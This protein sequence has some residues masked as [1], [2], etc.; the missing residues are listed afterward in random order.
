MGCRRCTSTLTR[1]NA[2]GHRQIDYLPLCKDL[3]KVK[4]TA[5]VDVSS[6]WARVRGGCS[7]AYPS[8]GVVHERRR[9]DREDQV[10]AALGIK[11]RLSTVRLIGVRFGGRSHSRR[12]VCCRCVHQGPGADRYREIATGL[13]VTSLCVPRSDSSDPGVGFVL[14]VRQDDTRSTGGHSAKSPSALAAI[15]QLPP[16]DALPPSRLGTGSR[17][18]EE[19][20]TIDVSHLPVP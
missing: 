20:E 18:Q 3:A 2:Y 19:R 4:A 15:A 6:R 7:G 1:S 16:R 12:R 8:F 13:R 5:R 10:V 9:D 11:S 14:R 17:C